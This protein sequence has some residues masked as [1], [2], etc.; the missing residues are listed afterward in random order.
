M[1]RRPMM[2]F[3]DWE[4]GYNPA[5]RCVGF[6]AAV[7]DRA[8]VP[9]IV[10]SAKFR[11]VPFETGSPS[12]WHPF[13]D[14]ET[15]VYRDFVTRS[16][17]FGAV[18]IDD[19]TSLNRG[20]PIARIEITCVFSAEGTTY[21]EEW[22]WIHIGRFVGSPEVGPEFTVIDLP[23]H[24]IDKGENYRQSLER[25]RRWWPEMVLDPSLRV[26]R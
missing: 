1:A 26:D 12:A 25:R 15:L 3:A 2:G 20:A 24:R 17:G 4:I 19:W 10:R 13:I 18:A 16:Y 8:D 9:S 22:I 6:T 21:F 11:I 23:P 14:T 7:V 5:S